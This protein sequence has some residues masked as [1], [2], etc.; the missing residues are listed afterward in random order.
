MATLWSFSGLQGRAD[1]GSKWKFCSSSAVLSLNPVGQLQ[2]S[3]PTG[4]QRLH[5]M[6][7]GGVA[8]RASKLP[9]DS[10]ESSDFLRMSRN[11]DNIPPASANT[12][13]LLPSCLAPSPA[14]PADLGQFNPTLFSPPMLRPPPQC[15]FRH[16][17]GIPVPVQ[18][19]N[20]C[21]R[22]GTPP[23]SLPSLRLRF[24]CCLCRTPTSGAH[25]SQ[26]PLHPGLGTQVRGWGKVHWKELPPDPGTS[27]GVVVIKGVLGVQRDA[28]LMEGDPL[29]STC[30]H[31]CCL[32]RH[33]MGTPS[34][35]P[36]CVVE[37]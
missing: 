34:Q 32:E 25:F 11:G 19:P 30:E 18:T 15:S 21:P 7:G 31:R 23:P 36:R 33:I 20:S 29:P 26:I 12:L 28:S 4:Q 24:R 14:H 22:S 13:A 37:S 9:P 8:R 2:T 1:E 27:D 6:G 17:Q 3:C 16:A 35:P 10:T 5:W